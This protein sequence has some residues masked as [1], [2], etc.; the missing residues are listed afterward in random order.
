[1][2]IIFTV[3]MYTDPPVQPNPSFNIINATTVQILWSPPF[4]WR[5]YS[6]VIFDEYNIHLG[7]MNIGTL[8][9]TTTNSIVQFDYTL[10]EDLTEC[11][12]VIV[13]LSAISSEQGETEPAFLKIGLPTGKSTLC[14]PYNTLYTP[15]SN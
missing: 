1:M 3:H 5:N 7:A 10:R 14:M 12:E 9:A 4:L 13:T 15:L 6:L 8:P 11:S 2:H